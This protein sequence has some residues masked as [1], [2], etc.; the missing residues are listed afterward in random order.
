MMTYSE[1]IDNIISSRGVGKKKPDDGQ[2]YEVHHI[3]PRAWGGNDDDCNLVCLLA[4]EHYE[5]H[6]L[7]AIENPDDAAMCHAWWMMA[8]IP[9]SNGRDYCVSMEEYEKSKILAAKHMRE[10]RIGKRASDETRRKL[11]EANKGKIITEEHKAA[12]SIANSGS[13]NPMYGKTGSLNP[14][15]GK[16]HT[17]EYIESVSGENNIMWGKVPITATPAYCNELDMFFHSAY[18]GGKYVGLKNPNNVTRALRGERK[19]A[20]KHPVTGQ[21]LTWRRATEEE[22]NKYN[23]RDNLGVAI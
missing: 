23:L 14:F 19:T 13:G 20:G 7:L 8:H 1:F 16:H 17:K 21:P 9:N 5:A 18:E 3:K 12:I 10:M 15:F 6:K 4:R 2:Y 22:I 11:S